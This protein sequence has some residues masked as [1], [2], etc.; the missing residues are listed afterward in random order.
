VY[1]IKASNPER[2]TI[3]AAFMDNKIY[4]VVRELRVSSHAK[5]F[6]CE[7]VISLLHEE[8]YN[9]DTECWPLLLSE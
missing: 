8:D 9:E 1:Y 2:S 4:K 5:L 7:T 6:N 3:D